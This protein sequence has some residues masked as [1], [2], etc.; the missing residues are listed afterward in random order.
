MSFKGNAFSYKHMSFKGNASCLH[1][2]TLSLISF[3][4]IS[5]IPGTTK[6]LIPNRGKSKGIGFEFAW[7]E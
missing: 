4:L 5:S 6:F 2:V 7:V 1:S 3:M